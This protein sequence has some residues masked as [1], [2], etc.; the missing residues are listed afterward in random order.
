VIRDIN[1]VKAVTGLF[2]RLALYP[3]HMV[4]P[5]FSTAW[6]L[7][8]LHKVII[9]LVQ[10]WSQPW[11]PPPLLLG[12]C[13]ICA[14][15]CRCRRRA[16]GQPRK[17][18]ALDIVGSQ[19]WYRRSSGRDWY[20]LACGARRLLSAPQCPTHWSPAGNGDVLYNV[21]HQNIRLHPTSPSLDWKEP[22]IQSNLGS[23][24]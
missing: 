6:V 18:W 19:N 7:F 2:L 4:L 11:E 17:C 13:E 9:W 24:T 20:A 8:M 10:T 3:W 1:S 14:V 15:D 22:S 12:M 21:V 16:T 23:R 5:E